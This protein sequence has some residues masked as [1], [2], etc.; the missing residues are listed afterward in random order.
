[1]QNERG[2]GA[3]SPFSRSISHAMLPVNAESMIR[4]DRSPRNGNVTVASVSVFWFR[5]IL[6]ADIKM[7]GF[8]PGAICLI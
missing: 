1:M 6:L 5:E 4:I 8:A 7:E 3:K 2:R